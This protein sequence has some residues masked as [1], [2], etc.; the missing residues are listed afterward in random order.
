[1][2]RVRALLALEHAS[3]RPETQQSTRWAATGGATPQLRHGAR[4]SVSSSS[5][6]PGSDRSACG[7]WDE[8]EEKEEA[9]ATSGRQRN[10]RPSMM[11]VC[12]TRT[13]GGQRGAFIKIETVVA[14]SEDRSTKRLQR[15]I[16]RL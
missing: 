3:G 2:N 16:W 15:P 11:L 5:R 6:A 14:R 13:W 12:G 8:E 4:S 7:T 9:R 1:M 10:A